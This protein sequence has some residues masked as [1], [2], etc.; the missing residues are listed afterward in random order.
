MGEDWEESWRSVST[1]VI[2]YWGIYVKL[3][4]Q[5]DDGSIV[6]GLWQRDVN[7]KWT[8]KEV[9]P[10]GIAAIPT[11]GIAA[12]QV[13]GGEVHLFFVDT[14]GY[15][16]EVGI[17]GNYGDKPK[18]GPLDNLKLKTNK[19]ISVI[20]L[21]Q[22]TEAE[23]MA[24]YYRDTNNILRE[25]KWN[26]CGKAK[27]ELTHTFKW[28][29]FGPATTDVKFVN[30]SKWASS[31]TSIRGFYQNDQGYLVELRYD[32]GFWGTGF[33]HQRVSVTDPP[34][35]CTFAPI[36]NDLYSAPKLEVF[37]TLDNKIMHVRKEG[38]DGYWSYAYDQT[39][40]SDPEVDGAHM[41][42]VGS[43]TES[44]DQHLFICQKGN[45]FVHRYH[46]K[47]GSWQKEVLDFSDAV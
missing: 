5:K 30:M 14:K 6:E 39:S 3:Y 47:G 42:G 43:L 37:Y 23:Q 12:T 25:Y 21:N 29:D 38:K 28:T 4:I 34:T 10:A 22:H 7:P 46:V 2:K 44:P 26:A 20:P 35:P 18:P 41:S 16:R 13:V 36:A 27:W 9:V 8:F 45:K 24:L 1:A 15:I 17:Y 33:L 32:D 31:D 40:A 19:S 11:V